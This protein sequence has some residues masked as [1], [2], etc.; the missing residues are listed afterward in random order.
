MSWFLTF[1]SNEKHS[2][3]SVPN[4]KRHFGCKTLRNN[5][6]WMKNRASAQ[7]RIEIIV[8]A[9]SILLFLKTKKGHL[10]CWNGL[11][12]QYFGFLRG[13]FFI[14]RKRLFVFRSFSKFLHQMTLSIAMHF[15]F[16]LIDTKYL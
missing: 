8:F 2:F 9:G 16:G 14:G 7:I 1:K 6:G 11:K 10:K 3:E 13:I 15:G 5:C 12:K 4:E